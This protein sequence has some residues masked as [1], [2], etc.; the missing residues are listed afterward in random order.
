L[1]PNPI[2]TVLSSIAAHR[3]RALLMGGQACVL[4]GAAEFS[5]DTDFAILASPANLERLRAALDDLQAGV[6]AVPPFEAGYLRR[7][8]AVHFRAGH[9]SASGLRID[10]MTRMR[11]VDPFPQ[12]WSRR[13]SLELPG[14]I[15]CH[16][17]ALPDL[18]Q[19]KKTQRDKD[20]PMLRRLTEAHYFEHRRHASP[21]QVAFWLRE[22]RTPELLVEAARRWPRAWV[23]ERRRRTLLELAVHGREAELAVALAAEERQEREADAAYWKPLRTEL[24]RLRRQRR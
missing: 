10:V 12:L 5:R 13:T 7:G 15:R 24:Q 8:H 9:P 1:I 14:G 20:W 16:V 6:I 19:A 3:V 2:R 4:Y 11:G 23:R 22:L 21:A 17:M 18:V